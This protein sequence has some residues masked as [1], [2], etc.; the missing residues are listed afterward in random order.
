MWKRCAWVVLGLLMVLRGSASATIV[1]AGT[2]TDETWTPA[3]NPYVLQGSVTVAAGAT[4][5][6]E[7]GT[8]VEFASAPLGVNYEL[9]VAGTL[10]ATGTSASPVTFRPTS[11]NV[12]PGF[13]IVVDADATAAHLEQVVIERASKG[14][15]LLGGAPVTVRHVAIT[16]AGVGVQIEGGNHTLDS[17]SIQGGGTGVGVIQRGSL[18]LLNS[19]V[20]QA[21]TGLA[22]QPIGPR[23]LRVDQ[24]TIVRNQNG[25]VVGGTHSVAISNSIVANSVSANLTGVSLSQV[26]H[27]NIWSPPGSLEP[28]LIPPPNISANPLLS[29]TLHLTSNSPSRFGAQGGGDQG[30][31]PYI[32]EPTPGLLGTLWSDTT[33]RAASGAQLVAGDLTVA[34]GVTLTLEPGASLRMAF[35]DAMGAGSEPQRVEIAVRGR[36]IAHGDELRPITL[37]R[38]DDFGRWTGLF[39]SAGPHDLAHLTVSNAAV[40]VTVLGAQPPLRH[41]TVTNNDLGLRAASLGN[42]EFHGLVATRNGTAVDVTGHGMTRLVNCLLRENTTTGVVFNAAA[43]EA[44]LRITNCTLHD[45][46]SRG[47]DAIGAGTMAIQNTIITGHGGTGVRRSGTVAASLTFSNLWG[48][49][50]NVSGTVTL[51]NNLALDPQYVASNNPRLGAT[52]P[53]IDQGTERDA[54]EVDF[55]GRPRPLDGDGSGGPRYDLGAYE[56]ARTANCGDGELDAGELCDD[57]TSNGEPGRC[58]QTCTGDELPCGNGVVDPGE[59]CDD[60]NRS[61]LDG[62]L[63]TCEPAGCGDTF[64]TPGVEQCDDGNTIAT[65]ACTD[66]CQ[67]ARCGDGVVHEGSEVCDDGNAI[68]SDGCAQCRLATCGDGHIQAG[69]EACDDG[70]TIDSDACTASCQIARCGDGILRPTVEQCDDGNSEDDDSCVGACRHA[71]CGDGFVQ[72]GVEPC[73]DGNGFDLDAC[74]NTCVPGTCGDAR[75]QLGEQCDDGNAIETDACR[76]NCMTARCGDGQIWAGVETCDD[77]NTIATDGCT[78]ICQ[79]ARCGDGLTYQGVESCDDGNLVSTDGCVDCAEARCGDGYVRAGYEQCDDANTDDAD[80]CRNTC[81]LA[82]CGDGAVQAG[83]EC[84]DG[85]QD[86]ADECRSACLRARCGDGVTQIGVEACDDGDVISG[87][88]CSATCEIETSS[89]GGIDG[90][91]GGMDAQGDGGDAPASGCCSSGGGGEPLTGLAAIV[92]AVV[93]RRRGRVGTSAGGIR[94]EVG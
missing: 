44:S 2:I 23:T 12:G 82:R 10:A 9:R 81:Q 8:I 45:N 33:V 56:F 20:S 27:S 18:T 86:D 34:P 43:A 50:V 61:N 48:N 93:L 84:D 74:S 24:T 90:G 94:R 65:D 6:I 51:A 54:P 78:T 29:S 68:D 87:D 58:D 5:R 40:G 52:S 41:L 75:V 70:N 59:R 72:V 32:G 46:G 49:A 19:V 31:R 11:G 66:T 17:V 83:E 13:A 63:T 26:T 47:V 71:R 35:S 79:P 55:D 91:A 16:G 28:P 15:V 88:G 53:C 73:D 77:G 89:D 38:N 22:F 69:I 7:A 92:L 85:D 37:A 39:L 57:G 36:L 3:G 67:V 14:L 80:A 25:I 21:N 42:V 4:L 30:G 60:G 64:V 1:P 76:G 62:C